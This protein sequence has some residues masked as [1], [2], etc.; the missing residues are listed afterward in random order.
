MIEFIGNFL[1][2]MP[3]IAEIENDLISGQTDGDPGRTPHLN[4]GAAEIC[5]ISLGLC[6]I[7]FTRCAHFSPVLG[8]GP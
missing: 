3:A 5:C 7:L 1:A 4:A 2:E 8:Y 6:F